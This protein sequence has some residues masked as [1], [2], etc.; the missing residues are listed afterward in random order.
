M[1]DAARFI[2]QYCVNSA[3]QAPVFLLA[4]WTLSP[5]L[6]RWSSLAEHRTWVA[7]LLLAVVVPGMAWRPGRSGVSRLVVADP[8]ADPAFSH[9]DV[10]H[11]G[12]FVLSPRL[13]QVLLIAWLALLL[14]AALRLAGS[15]YKTRALRKAAAPV[16][17]RAQTAEI[18]HRCQAGFS[19][20]GT[21]IASAPE[22]PGPVTLGIR[23]PL[24]LLP[25]LL[26]AAASLEDLAAALGHECAHIER[27]DF[28][29]N[30]VYRIVAL[31]IAWHPVVWLIHSRIAATRECICD[32]MAA[33]RLAGS[34]PYARSLLRLAG[35]MSANQT[36]NTYP[37]IGLFDAGSLENRVMYLVRP[38]SSLRQR[39]KLALLASTIL[40]LGFTAAAAFALTAHVEEFAASAAALQPGSAT[41]TPQASANKVYHPGGDVSNPVL[42]YAPD[43]V[44]PHGGKEQGVVIVGCVVEADGL[45]SHVYIE[46]SLAK[47]YDQSALRAVRQY[48]FKPAMLGKVDPRPVAAAIKIEVSFRRY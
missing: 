18:W 25:P 38:R 2:V 34:R 23:K 46:R 48:R 16:A 28:L 31:P 24:L 29:L 4:A 3:W 32:R 27:R 9:R 7:T 22:L 15:L 45:P 26:A 30:L 19:V 1:S 37:A 5:L 14:W 17:F 35:A 33:D 11:P 44:F 36:L 43:P 8:T 42:T 13:F 40:F 47:P 39:S 21:A 20:S 10:F 6:R 12:A 41:S